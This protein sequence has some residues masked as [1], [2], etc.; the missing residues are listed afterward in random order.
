MSVSHS[1]TLPSTPPEASKWSFFGLKATV[2]TCFLWPSSLAISLCETMSHNLTVLSS[3]HEANVWLSGL[4]ES[5]F[6][7]FL[8]PWS[9][10]TNFR[11]GTSQTPIAPSSLAETR[12]FPS[13]LKATY[14][15]LPLGPGDKAMGLPVRIPKFDRGGKT[16]RGKQLAVRA[17]KPN[18]P[19]DPWPSWGDL[20]GKSARSIV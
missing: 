9:V 6:T 14:L 10:A 12:V 8:C 15:P 1:L 17:E 5:W 2:I 18:G 19:P 20:I 7:F 4:K 13:E 16:C 3:P 11:D